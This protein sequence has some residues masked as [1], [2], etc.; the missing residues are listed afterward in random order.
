MEMVG[1]SVFGEVLGRLIFKIELFRRTLFLVSAKICAIFSVYS[2]F[3]TSKY[4]ALDYKY[5][6]CFEKPGQPTKLILQKLKP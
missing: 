1:Y 4:A 5:K 6:D 2:I 3:L